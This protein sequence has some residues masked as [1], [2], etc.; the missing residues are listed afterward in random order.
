MYSQRIWAVG[1]RHAHLISGTDCNLYC[2]ENNAAPFG[3]NQSQIDGLW[4]K[5]SLGLT[6]MAKAVWNWMLLKLKHLCA[7]CAPI[8]AYCVPLQI[9]ELCK[10]FCSLTF[11]SWIQC[12]FQWRVHNYVKKKMRAAS[13]WWVCLWMEWT[14]VTWAV[15]EGWKKRERGECSFGCTGGYPA[16]GFHSLRCASITGVIVRVQMCTRVFV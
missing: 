2:A 9:P 4:G 8:P 7:C 10:L 3:G 5:W 1:T 15:R 6:F 12:C 14:S 13:E 11:C 16:P